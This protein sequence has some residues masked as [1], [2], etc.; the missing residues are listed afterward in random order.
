MSLTLQ[1]LLPS[2]EFE[3]NCC[4]LCFILVTEA[5]VGVGTHCRKGSLLIIAND[6]TSGA[7]SPSK[8]SKSMS[9]PSI[10]LKLFIPQSVGRI[11]NRR[12][13]QM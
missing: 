4:Y 10:I 5:F 3:L 8:A 6:T 12:K 7:Y 2:L 1:M 13:Q 11:V 9:G